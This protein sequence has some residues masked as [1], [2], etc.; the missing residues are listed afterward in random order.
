MYNISLFGIVTMNPPHTM[1]ILIKNVKKK[2]AVIKR[3]AEKEGAGYSLPL[4]SKRIKAMPY[5][6]APSGF[7]PFGNPL[8]PS[9]LQQRPYRQTCGRL[10]KTTLPHISSKILLS[11]RVHNKMVSL[12]YL[13]CFYLMAT[14]MLYV[15]QHIT[16]C[17]F[18]KLLS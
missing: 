6:L 13:Y 8:R 2:S 1:N 14:I 7:C 9:K 4:P 11:S 5:G 3:V 12:H 15:A 18:S 10:A 17:F 16:F